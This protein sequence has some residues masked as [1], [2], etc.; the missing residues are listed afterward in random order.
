MLYATRAYGLLLVLL[1]LFVV[2]GVVY[3]DL[4]SRRGW[5]LALLALALCCY[6]VWLANVAIN[7][8]GDP[9]TDDLAGAVIMAAYLAIYL[10]FTLIVWIGAL[11][12]AGVSRLWWW[13]GGLVAAAFVPALFILATVTLTLRL[14]EPG[15]NDVGMGL[16]LVPPVTMLA[17]GMARI[18]RPVPARAV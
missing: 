12:E 2:A 9:G 4:R 11:V 13:L 14:G 7:M 18:V 15:F 8:Q 17:Y 1:L 16:F 3:V 5:G 10:A 6:G